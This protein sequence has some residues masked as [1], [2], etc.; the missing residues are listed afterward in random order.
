MSLSLKYFN[1]TNK[2]MN[3]YV[4]IAFFGIKVVTGRLDQG[5]PVEEKEK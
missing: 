3:H 5:D 4:D 2:Y 1:A